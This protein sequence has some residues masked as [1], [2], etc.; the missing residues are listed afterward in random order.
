MKT[1]D[2]QLHIYCSDELKRKLKILSDANFRTMSSQAQELI[3]KA[4]DEY[5]KASKNNL[6]G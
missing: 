5:E 3:N 6:K 1:T 4:Y 2:K